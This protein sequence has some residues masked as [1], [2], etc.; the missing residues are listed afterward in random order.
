MIVRKA[1]RAD[2]LGMGRVAETAHWTSYEDLLRPDTIGRLILS[3]FSPSA[4]GRRLLRGGVL[5]ATAWDEIAGFADGEVKADSVHVDVIATD[6]SMRRRGIGTA[7]LDAVR[8]ASPELPAAADVLLGNNEGEQFYEVNGFVP[9]EIQHG[10]LF[11]ESVVERRWWREANAETQ[12][13][14]RIASDG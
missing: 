6:P 4:L 13:G 8:G 1:T 3:D 2:L 14:L 5:V 11:G 12:P 7:L 10:S 9:G